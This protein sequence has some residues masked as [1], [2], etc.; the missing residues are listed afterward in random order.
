M[1]Y[2]INS[3]K[4][5]YL[6]HSQSIKIFLIKNITYKFNF[7]LM[8]IIPVSVFFFIKYNLWVSIYEINSVEIIKGYTLSKMIKYQFGIFLLDLFV[9]SHFFS[10]NLS[11]DI[12]LGKISSFI[13]YPFHFINYQ[14]SQFIAN[15]FLQLLIGSTAILTALLFKVIEIDS[16][17][18]FIYFLLFVIITSIF[19]FFIQTIIGLFAFWIDETWSLNVSFRF[20]T[21][22]LSGAFIPLDLYPELLK[23]ILIWTPFPYLVYFPVK[24]LMGDEVPILFCVSILSV[25][26]LILIFIALWA[27]KKG[28]K[29][30]TGAGI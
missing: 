7:F 19:W 3:L 26:T 12:R 13:L 18:V 10:Q 29:L 27:W 4:W 6:K 25:W 23:N 24:I 8:M 22:F 15:K 1:T 5:E 11:T 14:L 9:R 28:L 16:F 2:F 20:I 21:A 17:S 30:Y